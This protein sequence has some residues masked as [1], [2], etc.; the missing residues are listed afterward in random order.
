MSFHC[1]LL[2]KYVCY[3]CAKPPVISTRLST[4]PRQNS[5]TTTTATT[6]PTT[7][8][9]TSSSTSVTNTTTTS[10]ANA[11]PNG[12]SNRVTARTVNK[13]QPIEGKSST[14]I[15]S[16]PSTSTSSSSSTPT[17]STSR[18]S[19]HVKKEMIMEKRRP[20]SHS[21]NPN[22]RASHP[23]RQQPQ[24]RSV[25]I[26]RRENLMHYFSDPLKYTSHGRFMLLRDTKEARL[27]DQS[28]GITDDRSVVINPVT[29]KHESGLRNNHNQISLTIDDLR[30]LQTDR[31]KELKTSSER[32]MKISH[33]VTDSRNNIDLPDIDMKD[34]FTDKPLTR[35]NNDKLLEKPRLIKK[36]E[37]EIENIS[38]KS[39]DIKNKIEKQSTNENRRISS[40]PSTENSRNPMNINKTN[41]TGVRGTSLLALHGLTGNENEH[42]K[43]SHPIPQRLN[44]PE[45]RKANEIQGSGFVL[46]KPTELTEETAKLL[47][48]SNGAKKLKLVLFE[49]YVLI[50]KIFDEKF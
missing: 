13:I 25:R 50:M 29:N 22:D 49:R 33:N 17:P 43:A 45:K 30:R 3:R 16:H 32:S 5:S 2:G 37:P 27:V 47:K 26:G 10:S 31:V 41:G 35:D 44:L 4:T 23:D 38:D 28:F 21:N 36:I 39:K 48:D 11:T 42:I 7:S 12:N 1:F 14:T 8:A 15:S 9:T 24:S 34:S 6:T 40:E 46:N 19:Y 18:A 20:R